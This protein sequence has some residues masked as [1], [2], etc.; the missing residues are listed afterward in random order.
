MYFNGFYGTLNIKIIFR[1]VHRMIGRK[2]NVVKS[3]FPSCCRAPRSKWRAS[4]T[5]PGTPRCSS[6]P[7]EIL[8]TS[9]TPGGSS[10]RR[11]KVMTGNYGHRQ[12][13]TWLIGKDSCQGDSGGPLVG[14]SS[15]Y[16]DSINKRYFLTLF[17]SVLHIYGGTPG[18]GSSASE[19]AAPRRVTPGP[20]LG[21]SASS[22]LWRSSSDLK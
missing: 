13:N 1:K 21:P 14:V 9:P 17:N 5:S 8:T 18:W 19:W 2:I 12:I 15:K 11:L 7:A 20:T 22:A 3:N 6:L 16:S 4:L 10:V